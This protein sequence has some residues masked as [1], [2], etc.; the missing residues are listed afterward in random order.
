MKTKLVGAETGAP[1]IL[2]GEELETAKHDKRVIS[3]AA[4]AG[5]QLVDAETGEPTRLTG[6]ELEV[7]KLDKK[8]VS[9]SSF[10]YTRKRHQTESEIFENGEP[11][12]KKRRYFAERANMTFFRL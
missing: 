10:L 12:F 8:L 3:K 4:F 2:I 11:P 1:T 9:K 6:E 5:R 7:A